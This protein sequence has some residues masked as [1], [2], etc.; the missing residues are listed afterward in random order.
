MN[1]RIIL[2]TDKHNNIKPIIKII[3]GRKKKYDGQ[4]KGMELIVLQN[5]RK[6]IKGFLSDLDLLIMDKMPMPDIP[7]L[8]KFNARKKQPIINNSLNLE[9][10]K[11]DTQ[12]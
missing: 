11:N 7:E 10:I 1:E 9:V 3:H 12:N 8:K 5:L 2:N 4:L 6:A